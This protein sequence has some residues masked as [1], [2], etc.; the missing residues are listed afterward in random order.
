MV[1]VSI[2]PRCQDWLNEV[3]EVDLDVF[4]EITALITALEEF[5]R[6]LGDP[7]SHPVVTSRF[8]L[9]A[10]RRTP[11]TEV[12]PFATQPPVLRLLYG[13][14]LSREEQV[15]VLLLGGDKTNLGSHWYRP[16]IATAEH[17][18]RQWCLAHPEFEPIITRGGA[19]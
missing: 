1:R 8:D 14:A 15:A 13:Y 6:Q 16:N 12:T 18:L 3:A 19:S 4:G 10:L 2:D 11:A 5:G 7:I 9:H 17:R